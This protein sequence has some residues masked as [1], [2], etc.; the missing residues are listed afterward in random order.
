MSSS[1]ALSLFP[2]S[3]L[4]SFLFSFIECDLN[5]LF[6]FL[7]FPHCCCLPLFFFAPSSGRFLSV[8]VES[9]DL[10]LSSIREFLPPD[11]STGFGK[12]FRDKTF[13]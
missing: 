9:L 11:Y 10:L 5:Y 1:L 8:L 13:T 4:F 3:S 7:S 12:G 6:F 2:L